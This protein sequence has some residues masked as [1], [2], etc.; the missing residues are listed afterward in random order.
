MADVSDALKTFAAAIKDDPSLTD[1]VRD[2]AT[3]LHDTLEA[4]S[5]KPSGRSKSKPAVEP[6]E[7]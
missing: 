3:E 7:G 6:V 5:S 1:G 4:A 2:A